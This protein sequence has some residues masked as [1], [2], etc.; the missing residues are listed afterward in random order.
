M[1]H[2]IV[3]LSF[4]ALFTACAPPEIDRR[5]TEGS[6]E[7]FTIGSSGAE[8]YGRFAEK[9][10]EE[11]NRTYLSCEI[12]DRDSLFAG[13]GASYGLW[14]QWLLVGVRGTEYQ[15]FGLRF[16]TGLVSEVSIG[17]PRFFT[18]MSAD[19]ALAVLKDTVGR[20][21][22]D[23]LLIRLKQKDFSAAYDSCMEDIAW[24][25]QAATDSLRYWTLY[26]PGSTTCAD[27]L[28]LIIRDRILV[29][30]HRFR[31]CSSSI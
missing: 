20:A 18:G 3:L 7:G 4:G 1:K 6:Y 14:K 31:S 25:P 12:V 26:Y 19:S 15:N 30:I 28:S 22:Y 11:G 27:G 24:D 10:L 8:A 5:Y 21:S 29:E 13:A 9:V 2:L 17:G 23:S 16:E